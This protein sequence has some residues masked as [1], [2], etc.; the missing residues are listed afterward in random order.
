MLYK[1]KS[2]RIAFI[3]LI[4]LTIIFILYNVFMNGN[5]VIALS[6]YGSRGQEVRQIQT[7]LKRWGYYKGSIDGIY[8]SK[9]LS[10]V[11]S[12]YHQALLGRPR[13]GGFGQSDQV[14]ICRISGSDSTSSCYF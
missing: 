5:N 8:G 14:F 2:K 1:E 9:T 11:S 13:I 6:K 12:R 3:I 10:D 7:K 4:L